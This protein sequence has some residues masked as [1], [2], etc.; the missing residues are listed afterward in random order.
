[1][2]EPK[3]KILV[4]DDEPGY[5]KFYN[6][7]LTKTFAAEVIEAADPKVAFEYLKNNDNPDLILLDMQ[8]PVMDGH[9]ALKKI[10]SNTKT[11]DIP[12]IAATA[13]NTTELVAGLLKLKISDYIV[14]PTNSQIAIQKI[15]KVLDSI[16]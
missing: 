6:K 7:I 16:E 8:M 11:K 13:L 1:M 5:R 3:Y 12:V 15:K 2:Q 10:R 4:I 9:T 14:K